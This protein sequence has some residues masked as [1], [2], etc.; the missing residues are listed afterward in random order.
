[1]LGMDTQDEIYTSKKRLRIQIVLWWSTKYL[2][3]YS[4]ATVETFFIS[5]LE[6]LGYPEDINLTF[7][8]FSLRESMIS[9]SEGE[10]IYQI[11]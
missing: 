2:N 10:C 3:F 1:M 6:N 4:V 8:Y 5:R 7:H 9:S 11:C